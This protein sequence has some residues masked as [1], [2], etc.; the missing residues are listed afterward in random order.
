M[1]GYLLINKASD[2][3]N[4]IKPN[5]NIHSFVISIAANEQIIEV[6]KKQFHEFLQTFP[7]DYDWNDEEISK[8]YC[9]PTAPVFQFTAKLKTPIVEPKHTPRTFSGVLPVR[10]V[11]THSQGGQLFGSSGA[12][13]HFHSPSSAFGQGITQ[14]QRQ[15]SPTLNHSSIHV[16][17]LMAMDQIGWR[18][19]KHQE[20]NGNPCTRE[21]YFRCDF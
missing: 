20:A 7:I 9:H 15:S 1:G 12:T 8:Q 4:R 14:V 10:T 2:S 16:G 5:K 13:F 17:L 21:W 3:I 11:A 6:T 19:E 18:L